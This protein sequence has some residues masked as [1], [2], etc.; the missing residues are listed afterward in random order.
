MF[1]H[2]H[3]Q[4]GGNTNNP[5]PMLF[6]GVQSRDP[7][8]ARRQVEVSLFTPGAATSPRFI[9]RADSTPPWSPLRWG[10]SPC[11]QQVIRFGIRPGIRELRQRRVPTARQMTAASML[12]RMF[13]SCSSLFLLAPDVNLRDASPA[14]AQLSGD[15]KTASCGIGLHWNTRYIS[16]R[17]IRGLFTPPP[18]GRQLSLSHAT[19]TPRPPSD[20]ARS[21]LRKSP[22]RT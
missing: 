14:R 21:A 11:G 20:K 22:T 7:S 18:A 16:L 19:R 10:A 15:V 12:S 9:A 3:M 6:V 13:G 1:R 2:V 8:S 5:S 17:R 4:P